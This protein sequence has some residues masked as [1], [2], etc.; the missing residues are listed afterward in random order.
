ML[1]GHW[2]CEWVFR[3]S[4]GTSKNLLECSFSFVELSRYRVKKRCLVVLS[5]LGYKEGYH[6]H[7]LP[8]WALQVLLDYFQFSIFS[9]FAFECLVRGCFFHTHFFLPV[10]NVTFEISAAL[11]VLR[12]KLLSCSY[13]SSSRPHHLVLPC[14]AFSPRRLRTVQRTTLQPLT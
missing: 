2:D 1:V 6:S 7:W 8:S 10:F 14:Q 12:K 3:S 4:W 11:L 9:L 5:G 13:S